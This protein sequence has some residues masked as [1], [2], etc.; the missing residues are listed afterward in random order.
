MLKID[1]K[2]HRIADTD[3]PH[4]SMSVVFPS[5][6]SLFGGQLKGTFHILNGTIL[7]MEK[8]MKK[9]RSF[10]NYYWI[11]QNTFNLIWHIQSFHLP[12][13]FCRQFEVSTY[14]DFDI[15]N[16]SFDRN[17]HS[18]TCHCVECV[19]FEQD[20]WCMLFLDE[21]TKQS[22]Y[23]FNWSKNMLMFIIFVSCVMGI[24]RISLKQTETERTSILID[25]NGC[26]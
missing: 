18:P 17:C 25:G 2:N 24:D 22:V 16:V 7:T 1:S 14:C 4:Q 11:Y 8:W 13:S 21:N 6:R 26:Q 5:F 15:Y 3:P 12:H 10:M 19:K 20:R 9:V 23:E